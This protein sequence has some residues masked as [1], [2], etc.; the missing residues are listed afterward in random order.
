MLRTAILSLF[1]FASFVLAAPPADLSKSLV[2]DRVT[3]YIRI[4]NSGDETALRKWIE[5]NYTDSVLA[6]RPAEQR[7][8]AF[9]QL[10]QDMEQIELHSVLAIDPEQTTVLIHTAHDEWFK[11]GFLHQSRP[12]HDLMGL[13]VD[14][15]EAPALMENLPPLR[16]KTALDSTRKMLDKLAKADEFSGVVLVAKNGKPIF[17]KAYG[18]AD[19][20]NEVPNDL[21]TKFNIGSINK[22]FTKIAIAQLIANNLLRADEKVGDL[23]PDYPNKEVRSK[24]TVQQLLDHQSG[25][26]DFFGPEFARAAKD[27]LRSLADYLPFFA[28]KELEFKPGSREQ[29]SNGGYIIL[30][31]IIEKI[32]GQN[33]YDYVRENIFN[34]AGMEHSDWSMADEIAPA[35][36]IGYT[37]RWN[38]SPQD[39]EELRS[40]ELVQ[41]ARGSSA[42]GGYSTADDL[43]RFVNAV[44]SGELNSPEGA[45]FGIAGG[46]PGVNAAVESGVG[47]GYIV[48]VLCNWDP[49]SAERAA[50]K[51][52][53]WLARVK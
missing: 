32:S 4:F 18:F 14:P 42:G 46:S 21:D 15:T 16:E 47:N 24:V 9:R 3:D 23:L 7:L 30:G 39:S 1:L 13:R 52:R 36:A 41:P 45:N 43:L 27:R 20:A 26:P 28:E 50:G 29:Y 25:V 11:L 37:H 19:R 2:A 51:I 40:N 6:I 5:D 44:Q 12:P 48:I 34:R 53:R 33:Y 22:T 49:P 17:R 35:R 38:Y 8:N 31:L 10:K